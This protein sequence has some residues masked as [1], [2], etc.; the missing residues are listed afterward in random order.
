MSLFPSINSTQHNERIAQLTNLNDIF[1][2]IKSQL[3]IVHYSKES[4]EITVLIAKIAET[5]LANF[6]TYPGEEALS[7]GIKHAQATLD[8][9]DTIKSAES[10]FFFP[11]E[12]NSKER[13][14]TV[15]KDRK[16]FR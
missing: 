10:I 11:D 7:H 4:R 8:F 14:D 5:I 16:L 9:L 1:T 15:K 6:E 13:F 3:S 12:S 2:K